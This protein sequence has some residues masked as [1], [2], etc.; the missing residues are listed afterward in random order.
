MSVTTSSIPKDVTVDNLSLEA[1]D[2]VIGVKDDGIT[3][4]KIKDGEITNADI[5]T[6]ANISSSKIQKF[7]SLSDDILASHDATLVFTNSSPELKKTFAL[8]TLKKIPAT[9]IR[10]Y[11]EMRGNDN[12]NSGYGAYVSAQI[13]KNGSAVGTVRT[14][15]NDNYIAYSEDIDFEEGDDLE[16]YAWK[17]ARYES[18]Y[19]RNFRVL[20]LNEVSP[21]AVSGIEITN[22]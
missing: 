1:S 14:T 13:Y 22:S 9:K 4:P 16:I 12:P 10:I 8:D 18:C 17:S 15:N 6:D 3:E 7:Y 19:L 11:F 5:N 20:G 21:S 2:N